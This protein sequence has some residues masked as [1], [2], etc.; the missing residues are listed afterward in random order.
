MEMGTWKA[1][2]NFEGGWTGKVLIQCRT[3]SELYKLHRTVQNK[4]ITIQ[5]HNTCININSNYVDLG[6]YLSAADI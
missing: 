5:G 2:M 4:G 6:N 1:M 3:K